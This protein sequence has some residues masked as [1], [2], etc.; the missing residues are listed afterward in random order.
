MRMKRLLLICLLCLCILPAAAIAE[1]RALLVGCDRFLTYPETAPASAN[2]VAMMREALEG[3]A[4]NLSSLLSRASGVEGLEDLDSLVR[5]A[6]SGATDGDV[7][8]FYLS[9]H[10]ILEEE[11]SA[12]SMRFILSDGYIEETMSAAELKR[13]FDQ[14]GG[15][16]VLILDCCHSGAI[17]GKGIRGPFDNP[18][19]GDDYIIL[20]SGGGSQSSWF[21]KGEADE[22]GQ[23]AGFFS[24]ILTRG[25]SA[26][27]DWGADENGNGMITLS[28]LK[29]YL[30]LNHGASTVQSY[31]EESAFPIMLYATA[32]QGKGSAITHVSFDDSALTF[33]D[34]RLTFSFTVVEE[35]QLCYQLIPYRSGAWDFSAAVLLYDQQEDSSGYVT[36]G[37]KQ[38]TLTIS[39]ESLRRTGGYVL[40]QLLSIQGDQV[41]LISGHSVCITP[42]HA[43]RTEIESETIF[44]P[45]Q[46]DEFSF[47]I[48]HASPCMLTVT[49]ETEDGSVVRRLC[50]KKASRPEEMT[51]EGT[52]IS[53]NGMTAKGESC[54]AGTYVIHVKCFAGDT[55][56]EC[57]S[58]PF[59]LV[60]DEG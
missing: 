23:G 35:T 15:K 52:S 1:T 22:L 8:Y 40:L 57:Y 51:P 17:I 10:G 36:P 14:I 60:A 53:W 7:N 30:R 2:N 5:E 9:T 33:D 39:S 34:G 12:A 45:Q 46:K 55:F 38:R 26:A 56:T 44:A 59:M 13:I 20:T 19:E 43:P 29:R 32:A 41:M 49:V 25:I 4:L 31:P 48:T 11:G 3:G 37:Y 47:V 50:A 58:T 54:P 6:F 16:K 21:Y 18:F 42:Q 28:E 24:A 27:G